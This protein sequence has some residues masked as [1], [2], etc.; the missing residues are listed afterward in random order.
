MVAPNKRNQNQFE[1]VPPLDWTSEHVCRWL[2]LL[3]L[4]K[5]NDAFQDR[6][7]SGPQL[8]QMD[9]SKLKVSISDSGLECA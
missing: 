3:E 8:L 7:I 5:Y 4:D 9:G 1:S 2:I 6:N